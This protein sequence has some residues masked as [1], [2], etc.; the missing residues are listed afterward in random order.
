MFITRETDYGIR[1]IRAL[2]SGNKMNL[3]A[4]CEAE[5]VPHQFAY[6]ILR[7]LSIAGLVTISRGVNGGYLLNADPE[8]LTL[9]DIVSILDDDFYI[10]KCLVPEFCCERNTENH[11]CKVHKELCRIQH[12]LET[13][14]RK[15][16]LSKLI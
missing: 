7:K 9:F 5:N 14:L 12:V 16:P 11:N 10:N 8:K 4:I 13:E 2:S 3:T 6:K 15:T 1:T